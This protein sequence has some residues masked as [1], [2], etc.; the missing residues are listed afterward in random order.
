MF[1]RWHDYY[2]MLGPAAGGLI[3]LLFVVATLTSGLDKDRAIAGMRVYT[4]PNVFHLAAVLTLSGFALS[5]EP[6][7]IDGMAAI[8]IGLA[9]FGYATYV[10][11]G[12]RR[13]DL[14]TFE[15]DFW[16]YGVVIAALYLMVIAAGVMIVLEKAM[17]ADAFSVALLLLLLMTIRN[18]WDLVS[19]MAPRI[20]QLTAP[21][22]PK[23]KSESKPNPKGAKAS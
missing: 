23:A 4:A 13:G 14:Q 21:A 22:P 1:D 20:D 10:A 6:D 7:L 19:W 11:V 9:G 12:M 8:L 3:G 17:A 5:P 16:C 15:I 18:S 2:L